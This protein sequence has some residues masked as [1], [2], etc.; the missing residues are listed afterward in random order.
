MSREAEGTPILENIGLSCVSNLVF[1]SLYMTAYF[2]YKVI[3][4]IY[5]YQRI[6]KGAEYGLY[7]N[8]EDPTNII[9]ISEEHAM[10]RERV[11]TRRRYEPEESSSSS[12]QFKIKEGSIAPSLPEKQTTKDPIPITPSLLWYYVYSIGLSMFCLGYTLH[13][14]HFVSGLCLCVSSLVCAGWIILKEDHIGFDQSF[15]CKKLTLILLGLLDILSVFLCVYAFVTQIH[16]Y[17][18]ETLSLF[19]KGI[20]RNW[21]TACLFPIL[22]PFWIAETR[23]K[24]QSL[25]VP[26]HKV[27]LFGL[28]FVGVIS[29]GFLSMYI[30]LQEC[31][32]TSALIGLPALYNHTTGLS[33]MNGT[34]SHN[35]NIVLDILKMVHIIETS[36]RNGNLQQD[37]LGLN[38][39][40][41]FGE[42]PSSDAFDRN[43]NTSLNDYDEENIGK[44]PIMVV[45]PILAQNTLVSQSFA[46]LGMSMLIVPVMLYFAM[47]VFSGS[48]LQQE[49]LL[50]SSHSLWLVFLGHQTI[51]FQKEQGLLY[52]PATAIAIVSCLLCLLYNL[53]HVHLSEHFARWDNIYKDLEDMCVEEE[54][55]G[56]GLIGSEYRNEKK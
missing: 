14:S 32:P 17:D 28:P 40:L 52:L 16:S 11:K 45:L 18:K 31:S 39:N 43:E 56:G 41:L 37:W 20:W 34:I 51:L 42:T 47:V 7:A 19:W 10:K 23:H 25:Q 54:E 44:K 27:V 33:W 48:F 3:K 9:L 36:A 49:H 29:A 26:S 24:V 50:M 12:S 22:T 8:E 55:E 2:M 21:V 30:P 53:V 1:G 35:N 4:Q 15:S 38:S 6:R 5:Y 13:G 46:E